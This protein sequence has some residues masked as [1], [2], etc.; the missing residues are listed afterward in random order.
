MLVAELGVADIGKAVLLLVVPPMSELREPSEG[1]CILD[2]L[3]DQLPDHVSIVNLDRTDRHDL[4]SLAR[5]QF[6][7]E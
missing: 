6:S 4:L 5:R 1:L 2:L 3:R 7:D